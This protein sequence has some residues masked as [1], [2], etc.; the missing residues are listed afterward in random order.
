MEKALLIAE[1]PDMAAAIE[2][3][4]SVYSDKKKRYDITFASASGH[5]LELWM[6]GQYQEAWKKWNL[7]IL[8][9]IPVEFKKNV[10]KPAENRIK[11]IKNLI[12]KNN[13]S[14]IINA[15]DSGREGENIFT[16][17]YNYLDLSIPE[18]RFIYRSFQS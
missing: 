15:C 10:K 6:P 16:E 2:H 3:A 7:D 1:K 12:E 11:E 4:Y 17:I 13:Y 8:P 5:L 18:L 9:M 14:V